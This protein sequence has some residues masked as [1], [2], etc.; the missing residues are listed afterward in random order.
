MQPPG[1]SPSSKNTCAPSLPA[2][3]P[4]PAAW[5]SMGRACSGAAPNPRRLVVGTFSHL[6]PGAAPCPARHTRAS[7]SLSKSRAAP[8]HSVSKTKVARPRLGISTGWRLHP[9]ACTSAF[10]SPRRWPQE[11]ADRFAERGG[12]WKRLAPLQPTRSNRIRDRQSAIVPRSCS[13]AGDRWNRHRK[14]FR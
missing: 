8:P 11:P 5:K 10:R 7:A 3:E 13:K 4:P 2:L 14:L 12:R 1:P 6:L 9:R